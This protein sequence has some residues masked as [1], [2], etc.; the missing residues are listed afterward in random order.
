MF[1]TVGAQRVDMCMCVQVS[2]EARRGRLIPSAGPLQEQRLLLST[3]S[4]CPA[5]A[6]VQPQ[7]S[8]AHSFLLVSVN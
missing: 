1:M 2:R 6:P 4:V 3:Q 5:T 8:H 7:L